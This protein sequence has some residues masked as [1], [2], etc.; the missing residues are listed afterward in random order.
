VTSRRDVDAAPLHYLFSAEHELLRESIRAWAQRRVAPHIDEW[1]QAGNLP[2]DIFRELGDLGFLGLQYPEQYGGQGG[3]FAANVVLC[4]EL[5]HIG[6]ESLGAAV[7]VHTAMATPPIL[8]F[9]TESQKQSLLPELLSGRMIAALAISEPGGGSDVANIK[10]TARPGPSGWILDGRKTFITNARR[11]GI[12]LV[13]ARTPNGDANGRRSYSAFLVD[14][15][16]PGVLC[17][18]PLDK[19]GRHASD[20]CELFFDA[21][22]LPGDALLGQEGLGFEHLKWELEAERIIS[23]AASVALGEYALELALEYVRERRQFGS[24]IADFQA[25]RHELASRAAR[26]AA[27]RELVHATAWRFQHELA[28]PAA[29]SMC[30]LVASDALWEIADYALQLH[31][32]YGYMRE[33]P[34]GRVWTDAR[35]KRITAGTDEI[36]REIIAR[37]TIGRPSPRLP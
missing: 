20:T 33:Y 37:H 31:G 2:D 35:V 4:E 19:L 25:V 1:E 3:D 13:L 10:T 17:G 5:S 16:L 18:K 32:G 12:V 7:G 28:P 30:K 26:L 9:G 22:E 11:A 6:A 34:I 24:P 14:T 8:R 27:A 21:V 15:D 29:S 23:A 36:Q